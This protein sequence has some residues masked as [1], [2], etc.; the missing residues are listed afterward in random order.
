MPIVNMYPHPNVIA[1]VFV[2][3][4]SAWGWTSFTI[5]YETASWLPHM[6]ELLMLYDP[7]GYTVTVRRIDL[8][9]A[10]NNY[11]SVLRR[12]KLS[13]DKHIIIAC[14]IESLPEVLKQTQQVGLMTDYH[15]FIIANLDA[16]TIDLEPFQYSG[17]NISMIRIVNTGNPIL[18]KYG[19]FL[20]P[21]PKTNEE[22]DGQGDSGSEN[23]GSSEAKEADGAEDGGETV[24]AEEHE[25]APE[26]VEEGA[27][28]PTKEE[29]EEKNGI[30]IKLK[31]QRNLKNCSNSSIKCF[32]VILI[33][34]TLTLLLHSHDN[35]KLF[36][37]ALF[38]FNLQ[39]V[40]LN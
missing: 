38:K 34:R 36:Y 29:E 9:L 27:K 22:N 13:D 5:L 39:N 25:A 35:S 30:P 21:Q 14:S 23:P 17:T 11:R 4:V 19:T 12:V 16:H 28:S 18:E 8:G 32:N 10:H 26:N 15:Q 40:Y 20:N 3:M 7:K 2:D 6:S 31:L 33:R 1:R 37:R 24:E